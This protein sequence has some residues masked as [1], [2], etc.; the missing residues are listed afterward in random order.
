MTP[1]D[2]VDGVD[3]EPV[4][5]AALRSSIVAKRRA[6][7][8]ETRRADDDTL[9][10]HL[11]SMAQAGATMCAYVPVG[12][13]PGSMDILDALVA[14][15]VRVLLPIAREEAGQ[16]QPLQWGEYRIGALVDA[17]F[18]LREPRGPWLPAEAIASATMV[19]VPALAVDYAGARLGRGAGFYD[20]SLVLADPAAMLVAVVRDD[21]LFEH[22]PSEQHDV[23]MTHALTP[24]RGLVTLAR[25]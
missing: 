11:G 1:D 7:P 24:G 3:G 16:P 17:P 6:L 15:G 20:R 9:G 25:F 10:R 13:E 18:G 5:K 19:V 8:P 4:T 21:E 12:T 23:S 22:L 2:R 14:A